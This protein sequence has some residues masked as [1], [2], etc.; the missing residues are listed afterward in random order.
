LEG[1]SLALDRLVDQRNERTR[2]EAGSTR[3]GTAPPRLTS[4]ESDTSQASADL[5]ISRLGDL[6]HRIRW[7]PEP[8]PGGARLPPYPTLCGPAIRC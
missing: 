7:Q 1:G 5:P 6:Y 2:Y 3:A 4:I 8:G